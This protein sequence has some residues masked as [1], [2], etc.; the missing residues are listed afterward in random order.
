MQFCSIK[1]CLHEKGFDSAVEMQRKHSKVWEIFE[2]F[3]KESLKVILEAV[4]A[5][6][7]PP[8]SLSGRGDKQERVGRLGDR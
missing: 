6:K 1:L 3:R 2:R 5:P 4:G 7:K 8:K